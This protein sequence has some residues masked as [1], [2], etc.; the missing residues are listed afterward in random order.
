MNAKVRSE[1]DLRGIYIMEGVGSGKFP[2]STQQKHQPLDLH[3][4]VERR[5]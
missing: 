3:H 1:V 5:E 2:L 4:V